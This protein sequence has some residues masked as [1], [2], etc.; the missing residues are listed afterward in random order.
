MRTLGAAGV[1]SS[2]K[3]SPTMPRWRVCARLWWMLRW[4]VTTSR[5]A[6]WRYAKWT[7]E[8]R[9]VSKSVPQAAPARFAGQARA[10]A[11]DADEVL[12]SLGRPDRILID[13]RSPDV[14]RRGRT[15]RWIRWAAASAARFNRFFRDNLDASGCFKRRRIAPCLLHLLGTAAPDAV[16]HSCGSGVSACHNLLAME[17]AG[18]PGFQLYPGSWSEWCSDPSARWKKADGLKR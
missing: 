16:V 12:R 1:D 17:I 10:M 2:N 5:R 6:R 15:R 13:A 11:V 14:T 7:D 9:P 8:Q 3:S 4:S 18:L